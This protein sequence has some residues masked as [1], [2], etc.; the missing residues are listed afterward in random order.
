[1]RNKALA[2]NIGII[3]KETL[4]EMTDFERGLEL[5]SIGKRD[6]AMQLWEFQ[7][8]NGNIFAQLYLAEAL[9]DEPE[10]VD[11]GIHWLVR[12][13]VENGSPEALEWLIQI[14]MDDEIIEPDIEFAWICRQLIPDWYKYEGP[15]PDFSDAINA[16]DLKIAREK[17]EAIKTANPFDSFCPTEKLR[18]MQFETG[19]LEDAKKAFKIFSTG[20]TYE[21][22]RTRH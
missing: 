2:D 22:Q 12:A 6:D 19:F 8:E 7:A 18:R 16:I 1:M 20:G 13:G 21:N 10:T 5:E 11:D 15:D 14:F 9:L 4:I 17:L 3:L